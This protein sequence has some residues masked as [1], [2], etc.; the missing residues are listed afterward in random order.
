MAPFMVLLGRKS[1]VPIPSIGSFNFVKYHRQSSPSPKNPHF[2]LLIYFPTNI[3]FHLILMGCE[4]TCSDK[5]THLTIFQLTISLLSIGVKF[6]PMVC[7]CRI[8]SY[9][10]NK[11]FFQQTM[12]LCWSCE[13]PYQNHLLGS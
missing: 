9:L 1:I 12:T 10:G 3:T 13:L 11:T 4:L 6:F 8:S 7:I 5:Q 2:L